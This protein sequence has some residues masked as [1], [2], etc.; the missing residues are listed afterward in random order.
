MGIILGTSKPPVYNL[1]D[2][3]ILFDYLK[4]HKFIYTVVPAVM[5]YLYRGRRNTLGL[6]S[7]WIN[8]DI[9]MYVLQ[10]WS[11]KYK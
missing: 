7:D 2:N 3:I 5:C 9:K 10:T 11:F 1:S 8:S 4:L 6:N